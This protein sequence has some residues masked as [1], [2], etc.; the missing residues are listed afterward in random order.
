[1]YGIGDSSV[2]SSGYALAATYTPD[3]IEE[4]SIEEDLMRS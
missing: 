3:E 1:M 2:D 4:C